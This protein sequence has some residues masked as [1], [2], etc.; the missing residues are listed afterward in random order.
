MSVGWEIV[1]EGKASGTVSV[2][3]SRAAVGCD[4]GPFPSFEVHVA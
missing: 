2:A 3:V 4:S 1:V